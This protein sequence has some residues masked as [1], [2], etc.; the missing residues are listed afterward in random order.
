MC[1][2]QP[3]RQGPPH[4]GVGA[5]KSR[6]P[7]ILLVTPVLIDF[8]DTELP[9]DSISPRL[10]PRR[11][12][13]T[14]AR[15]TTSSKIS[16]N[17][18]RSCV[19]LC[20]HLVRVPSLGRV[21]ETVGLLD[22]YG[23]MRF[24]LAFG[25]RACQHQSMSK[26]ELT[27]ALA[28]LAL[29]VTVLAGCTAT[30]EPQASTP[31]QKPAVVETTPAEAPATA[32]PT[33]TPTPEPVDCVNSPTGRINMPQYAYNTR[34]VTVPELDGDIADSGPGVRATGEPTLNQ[35]GQI[36]SYTAQ[37]GD[38]LGAIA[39][40]FCMDPNSLASYNHTLGY[41]MQ[42]GTVIILRPAPDDPWSPEPEG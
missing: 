42:A 32:E 6:Q 4:V 34:P 5:F 25:V 16:S 23:R 26:M 15:T 18:T 17:M 10:S 36:V 14:P 29:A 21:A 2:G 13:H 28:G 12:P 20:V 38:V 37:P 33:P 27:A 22:S 31:S 39:V 30:T 40:R 19:T 41:D 9:H 11:A 35:A 24:T 1:P 3:T 8:P 7:M